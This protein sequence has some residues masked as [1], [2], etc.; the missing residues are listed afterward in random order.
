MKRVLNGLLLAGILVA[1]DTAAR[2]DDLEAAQKQILKNWQA[3][4]SMRAVVTRSGNARTGKDNPARREEGTIES[5]RKGDRVLFRYEFKSTREIVSGERKTV[6][7]ESVLTI[8]DG[9]FQYE[10]SNRMGW[11]SA[12]KLKPDPLFGA[13]IKALLEKLKARFELD[14]LEETSVEGH[15]VF[16]ILATRKN[17]RPAA[18]HKG[19]V[20]YFSKEHGFLLKVEQ[21]D[22]RGKTISSTTY[23]DLE[24]DPK[25]DPKRF[26]FNLPSGVT[27]E[28][29]TSP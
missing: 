24:I 28:D 18:R 22:R 14:L 13:D 12:R 15:D 9:E 29:K 19:Q 5:L 17:A 10:L 20:Y 21:Q 7:E 2:A 11:K 25:I 6:L 27:L 3:H 4:H 8:G 16:V 1:S 23:T 26:E